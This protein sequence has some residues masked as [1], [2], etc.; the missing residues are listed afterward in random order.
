MQRLRLQSLNRQHI[1]SNC[2]ILRTGSLAMLRLHVCPVY[3]ILTDLRH[4]SPDSSHNANVRLAMILRLVPTWS[5][6]AGVAAPGE[7]TLLSPDELGAGLEQF[8]DYDDPLA[9]LRRARK[10]D[11]QQSRQEAL[12]SQQSQQRQ[13]ELTSQQEDEDRHQREWLASLK[14]Q[15]A[16]AQLTA[17]AEDTRRAA[18]W[19]M[20][21]AERAQQKAGEE[22]QAARRKALVLEPDRRVY[23]TRDGTRLYGET[24]QEITDRTQ[25][26]EARRLQAL[27][28]T[29]TA[30]EDYLAKVA[31]DRAAAKNVAGLQGVAARLDKLEQEIK[32]DGLSPEALILARQQQQEILTAL[33]PEAQTEYARLQAARNDERS[34]AYR[35]ADSDFVSA[36]DLNASFR[37]GATAA[38]TAPAPDPGRV[39]VYKAA[40]DY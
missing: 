38:P 36:P 18:I 30:Y 9:I 13:A 28:P 19:A 7:S 23:F 27:H 22:L 31:A 33:P 20:Q 16:M 34:L 17:D 3:R 40:P 6:V 1:H 15:Q 29:A 14:Y 25:I 11:K 35:A 37:Q 39:P 24:D 4:D 2:A 12:E 10:L 21:R 32:K 8:L 5:K 26:A